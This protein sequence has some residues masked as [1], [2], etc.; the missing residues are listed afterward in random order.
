MF[1]IGKKKEDE[2]KKAEDT[3]VKNPEKTSRLVKEE[4]KPG[5]WALHLERLLSTKKKGLDVEIAKDLAREEAEP[6][7]KRELSPLKL[8]KKTI[9]LLTST[10]GSRR[11]ALQ[12]IKG[13]KPGMLP[14]GEFLR[15]LSVKRT[16]RR[17]ANMVA[18]KQRRINRLSHA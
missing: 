8:W 6:K 15:V 18:R 11:K 5:K 3:E 9:R 12:Q 10:G 1:G 4:K 16:K 17:T 2:S 7:V 13:R 14:A